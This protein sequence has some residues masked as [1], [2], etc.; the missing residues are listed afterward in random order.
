MLER[1]KAD[2]AA[3]PK[4]NKAG[5][6][7]IIFMMVVVIPV[8]GL[9]GD[10]AAITNGFQTIAEVLDTIAA[11][12]IVTAPFIVLGWFLRGIIRWFRKLNSL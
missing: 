11:L 1:A 12:A 7:F 8:I 5:F 3:A 4:H 6:I 2:W 9:A 10:P